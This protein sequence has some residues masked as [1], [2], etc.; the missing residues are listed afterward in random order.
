[1]FF[2]GGKE[3]GYGG[4]GVGLRNCQ[5]LPSHTTM[6]KKIITSSFCE[7]HGLYTRWI[8][9]CKPRRVRERES[10]RVRE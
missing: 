7:D 9:L 2:F 8:K 6:I 3:G 4:G 5:D 10:E 1:M